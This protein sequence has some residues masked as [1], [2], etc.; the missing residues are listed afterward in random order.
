[1]ATSMIGLSLQPAPAHVQDDI[2]RQLL[3]LRNLKLLGMLGQALQQQ[4]AQ[5]LNEAV[6][7]IKALDAAKRDH[8]LLHP[9]VFVWCE[10]VRTAEPSGSEWSRLLAE[11]YRDIVL[12][13]W[14]QN[15]FVA[16]EGQVALSQNRV[17]QTYLV[18]RWVDL[19]LDVLDDLMTAQLSTD[20][21]TL[22]GAKGNVELERQVLLDSFDEFQEGIALSTD[23][24]LRYDVDSPWLDR[25]IP[26]LSSKELGMDRD[27]KVAQDPADEVVANMRRGAELVKEF[28]PEMYAELRG[29]VRRL[30]LVERP[31]PISFSDFRAHGTTLYAHNPHTPLLWAE[32][33]VHESS[34]LRLNAMM[35]GRPHMLND[36]SERYSSPWR[37]ELRPLF[38]IYHGCFVHVRVMELYKQL[39]ANSNLYREE[40][41]AELAVK[42]EQLVK[43]LAMMREHGKL[44]PDGEELMSLM[45]SYIQ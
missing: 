29:Y 33:I 44:T 14:L 42:Q 20:S 19:P 18:R 4:G 22:V 11:G 27:V 37:Q 28:W 38:G 39:L 41:L 5:W 7:A 8:L 10:A 34:H 3:A 13:L 15:G 9:S 45:E 35:S 25:Y 2:P 6:E 16:S 30:V 32:W 26:F 43:G 21:I 23:I 12:P 36:M 40:L 17:G 1:M 31:A 24:E